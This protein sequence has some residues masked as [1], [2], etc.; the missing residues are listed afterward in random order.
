[1]TDQMVSDI[2]IAPPEVVRH[3]TRDL[4]AALADGA[5]AGGAAAL[6]SSR[7]SAAE[8]LG[9]RPGDVILVKGSRGVGLEMVAA[10]LLE[11]EVT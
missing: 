9:V 11:G 2:A 5:V 6:V 7:E 1:M 8:V 4:A 10:Q 3:A